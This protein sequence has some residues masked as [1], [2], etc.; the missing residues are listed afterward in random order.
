VNKLEFWKL[1]TE[2]LIAFISMVAL[3]IFIS[4]RLARKA[5]VWL[6]KSGTLMDFVHLLTKIDWRNYFETNLRAETGKALERPFGTPVHYCFWD[7]LL[8]NP[9]YLSKKPLPSDAAIETAVILGL[10]AKKPLQLKFPVMIAGMS[11]GGALSLTAKIALAKAASMAGIAGN[12]GS[13]PFLA[14]ERTMA[15]KY[16][17]QYSRGFWSKT[18]AVLSQADMIEIALGHGAW[19]SA[20]VRIK[21]QALTNGYAE[22]METIAG[23]DVLIEARFTEVNERKDWKNLIRNLKEVTT[24]VPIAVK[25]GATH[26]LEKELELILEGGIDVLVI[27]GAEGGSH[28][29]PPVLSDDVGLPTLPGLCRAARFLKDKGLTDEISLVV[30][31][32]LYTPGDFLKCLAL[33]ADAVMIGTIAS[34]AMSH[35]QVTKSTPWE[36]PTG[37]IY[38]Q[39]KAAKKFNPDLGAQDLSH[40][41]QS[42]ALEMKQAARTMGKRSLK[43]LNLSDLVALDPLYAQMAGVELMEGKDG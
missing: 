21:G 27:D 8:F 26:Y 43:E 30:G 11:Y 5:S 20:P 15:E 25:I 37:L 28:S 10:H 9:S 40:Y 32:G 31:G 3:I 34:L 18:A 6:W 17:L 22:S 24:G 39:G 35:T 14:E 42:C 41:L 38:Y 1:F 12:S 33:G 7:R 29:A 2:V 13:G 23:L 4:C 16:I 19:A 36:P